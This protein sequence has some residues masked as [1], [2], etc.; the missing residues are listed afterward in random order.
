MD[1]IRIFLISI[2]LLVV[3]ALKTVDRREIRGPI[4]DFKLDIKLT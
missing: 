1:I 4:N 3:R 2:L